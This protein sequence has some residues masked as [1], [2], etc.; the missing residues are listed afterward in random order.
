[1]DM[2]VFETYKVGSK[3]P[4]DAMQQIC[5]KAVLQE[6]S[7]FNQTEPT[8]LQR[9]IGGDVV[10]DRKS[11][12]YRQ[13]WK[14]YLDNEQLIKEVQDVASENL[15]SLKRIYNIENYYETSLLPKLLSFPK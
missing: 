6:V 8:Q 14:F 4:I 3:L 1:M 10:Y 5:K 7:E 2:D 13:V 12:Y 15:K 9:M 11:N